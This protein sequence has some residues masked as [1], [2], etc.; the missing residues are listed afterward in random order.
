MALYYIA[1]VR[2]PTERAHGF[3]IMRMCA[4]FAAAGTEVELV[5]PRKFHRAVGVADPFS[6]Y[7]LARTFAYRRLPSLDVLGLSEWWGRIGYALDTSAFLLSL[8]INL[9]PVAASVLY[10]RDPLLL[11]PFSRE[12]HTLVVEV[13]SLP[14]HPA[15]LKALMRAHK[16]I[17]LTSLLKE[18]LVKA[19]ISPD[20]ILVAADGV[21]VALFA[22]ALTQAA[23]RK[24]TDL[25]ANDRIV[26][27]TGHLYGWKGVATLAEAAPLVPEVTFVFVGGIE[28]EL[29]D[30]RAKY[31]SPNIVSL[32]FQSRDR[33][34]SY[35]AAADILAIPNSGKERIS[36]RYTSPLKLFEYMA[37]SK[38]IIASDL[39]SMR[40]VLSEG[41]AFLV[42]PDDP[43]A[44][45]AGIRAAFAQPQEASIRAARARADVQA[46][47]WDTRAHS[48]LK[49]LVS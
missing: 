38:P 12:R 20:K 42:A 15:F 1:N 36:A 14:Q 28:P 41:N 16:V 43:S 37:A 5:V 9:R 34:P 23:A 48:I 13:H 19:G 33:I 21:D 25:P 2:L 11:R 24:I 40:E 29:S 7:H 26:L 47:S 3:Q 4:A 18:D 45:A 10:A 8:I 39:P 32:P 46:H 17:A 49:S 35:L 44:F 27:Y 6:Y 31:R 22:P 30:F